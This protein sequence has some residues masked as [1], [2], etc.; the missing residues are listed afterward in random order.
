MLDLPVLG[1]PITPTLKVCFK[2]AERDLRAL[3]NKRESFLGGKLGWVKEGEE[4]LEKGN[5]GN[6][7]RRWISHERTVSGGIKSMLVGSKKL[8]M[9]QFCLV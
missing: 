5:T 7:R 4:V 2:A 9:Y 3:C 1:K 6:E 8:C